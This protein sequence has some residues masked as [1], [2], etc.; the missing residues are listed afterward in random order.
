MKNIRT[1][2][3]HQVIS[4]NTWTKVA[5]FYF[6]NEKKKFNWTEQFWIT[7]EDEKEA[8]EMFQNYFKQYFGEKSLQVEGLQFTCNDK[9]VLLDSPIK[10]QKSIFNKM[11]DMSE[12]EI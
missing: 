1:K 4:F 3:L 11:I 8:K 12:V 2:N 10:N 9:F 7:S 5:N 6:F